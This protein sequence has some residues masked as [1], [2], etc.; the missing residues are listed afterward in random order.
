[1]L[2]TATVSAQG[3]QPTAA[4]GPVLVFEDAADDQGFA[5]QTQTLPPMPGSEYLDLR[6]LEVEE[7]ADGFRLALTLQGPPPDQELVLVG[8]LSHTIGFAYGGV[9]YAVRI[10]HGI[11]LA[12]PIDDALL[13]SDPEGGGAYEAIQPV[14]VTRSGAV[15]SAVVPRT[16]LVDAQGAPASAGTAITS[17]WARSLSATGMLITADGSDPVPAQRDAAPDAGVTPADVPVRSG[18]RQDGDIRLASAHP[19]RASNGEAARFRFA[20]QASNQGTGE[21]ALRLSAVGLP[22][23]WNASFNVT[24]LVVPPGGSAVFEVVADVPFAHRHGTFQTFTVEATSAQDPASVGRILLGLL[25]IDPAQPAGHH[26][27]LWLHSRRGLSPAD[28]MDTALGSASGA[29][30][31]FWNTQ[32]QDDGDAGVAVPPDF[33]GVTEGTAGSTYAWSV[34]L[35]PALALG[36][37]FDL[38]RLGAL[39]IPIHCPL[40]LPGAT[41]Q[42]TVHAV[43]GGQDNASS[44]FDLTRSPVLAR[45]GRTPPAELAPQSTT[46]FTATLAATEDGDYVPHRAGQQLWLRIELNTTRADVETGA[47]TPTLAPGGWVRLPLLEYSDRAAA[48]VRD[49]DEEGSGA[50]ATA[51]PHRRAPGASASMAVALAGAALAWRRR[52]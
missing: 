39:E 41:L 49:A 46:T 40:P 18:V 51:A 14:E 48:A 36:L 16:L 30:E 19:F 22:Q 32:E 9:S 2:M 11:A 44:G 7:L 10:D 3:T 29:I 15:L 8:S 31:A 25:Y 28:A 12:G 33:N 34:P 47:G 1:M 20:L 5:T 13:L 38:T 6:A 24:T 26:D 50:P 17:F 42:V 21:D 45:S 37:D 52:R 23:G 43:A 27:T 4:A 35:Q